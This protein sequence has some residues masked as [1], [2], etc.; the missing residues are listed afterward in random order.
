MT[1]YSR[2]GEIRAIMD[3]VV[4]YAGERED[5]TPYARLR[6]SGG[7][8]S[9][10]EGTNLL[11]RAGQELHAGDSV[12]SLGEGESLITV[13]EGKY[14]QVKRMLA[15]RGKPVTYLKRLSMGPLQLDGRLSAGQW[16]L[17]EKEE[18]LALQEACGLTCMTKE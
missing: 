3:G 1:L 17:L 4:F 9:W 18:I 15:S 2:E 8:E 12:G 6:H 5:G 13:C 7:F 14:H 16:R 10:Y 11:V